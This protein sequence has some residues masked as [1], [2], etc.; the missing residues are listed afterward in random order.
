M[1]RRTFLELGAAAPLVP[2]LGCGGGGSPTEPTDTPGNVPTGGDL[3]ELPRL[4]NAGGNPRVFEAT[5]NAAQGQTQFIPGVDTQ[6]W[7][8]N[9]ATPGPLIDVFEGDT[10]RI[11][12][13]NNLAQ[14]STVHWHGV[15]VPPSQDGLPMDPIP[16]GGSRVYQF[17]IPRGIAGT[18]W[19]HP[20]P[21]VDSAEQ[22]SRGLAGMF[23]IRAGQ[24]PLSGFEQ[25]NLFITDLRLDAQ[26][27]IPASTDADRLG[28]RVGNHLL[29]NGR[30]LPR[31]T[32]RPGSIQ[33]W[34]IVNATTGRFLRLALQNHSLVLVGTDGGL[35]QAPVVRGEVFLAPAERAEVLV[36]ANQ[37][38][39]ATAQFVA[40]PYDPRRIGAPGPS[41]QVAV[42]TLAYTLDAPVATPRIPSALRS[43]SRYGSA[44]VRRSVLFQFNGT[45]QFLVNG[46]VFDPNRVD[47]RSTAGQLEE[48]EVTNV[49]AMDH[50]FHIHQGQFQIVNRTRGGVTTNELL[51]WKDTFNLTPGE[52]VR[53]R[54]LF[55]R[56]GLNVFHCH[57]VEHEAH[58][59]MGV[60]EIR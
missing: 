32:I 58:G 8:F 23:I 35:L 52:T 39:G 57:I 17:P 54:M 24:D 50:P 42:A 19:Y 49:A 28:G 38:S 16:P 34:R 36:V 18:F 11:T 53:F 45:N 7:A 51:A 48:W 46:K 10:V 33:R 25:K 20:H 29:V 12:Y 3:P 4:A 22:V 2:L 9:G 31:I 40:L 15:P 56:K 21:H 55:P 14:D 44:N 5:L 59:M 30:E 26:G 27:Q 41:A 60:H 13:H 1:K 37:G 43:I 6:V 47:I